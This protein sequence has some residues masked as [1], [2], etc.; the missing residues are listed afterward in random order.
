MNEYDE[1][2]SEEELAQLNAEV[3]ER[4]K[5]KTLLDRAREVLGPDATQTEAEFLE[6]MGL[7]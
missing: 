2:V 6:A 3:R 1:I 4:V 7:L 5:G